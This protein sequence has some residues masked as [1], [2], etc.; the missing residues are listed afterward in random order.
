MSGTLNFYYSTMNAGKTYHLIKRAFEA[1]IEL[2]QAVLIIGSQI[3]S[4]RFGEHGIQLFSRAGTTIDAQYLFTPAT[5]FEEIVGNFEADIIFVDECQFLNSVQ[6]EQLHKIAHA[7]HIEINC[8]GIMTDFQS[9][10]F[11]GS[12]SLVRFADQI[13]TI[14]TETKCCLCLFEVPI[15]NARVVKNSN[16]EIKFSLQ[17]PKID[18]EETEEKFLPACYKCWRENMT[19]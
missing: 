5:D 3:S 14:K 13:I 1:K 7:K 4:R 17:G 15:I 9:H 8:Y 19:N 18:I 2:H 11:E 10:L 12:E 6:V 16:N